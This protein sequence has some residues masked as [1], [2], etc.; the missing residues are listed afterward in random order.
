MA[1]LF[2]TD[3]EQKVAIV[4]FG[5]LMLPLG[6]LLGSTREWVV[7]IEFIISCNSGFGLAAGLGIKIA[8]WFREDITSAMDL[9]LVMTSGL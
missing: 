5:T 4:V 9:E 3:E 2:G 7:E 8:F 1:I 6:F